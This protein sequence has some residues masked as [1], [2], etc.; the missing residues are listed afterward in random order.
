MAEDEQCQACQRCM[1]SLYIETY[2]GRRL[3]YQCVRAWKRLDGIARELYDRE[4]A[5]EEFLDPRPSWF[6][7]RLAKLEKT[8][9]D[10]LD[11][12]VSGERKY[13]KH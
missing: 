1:L 9:V 3:C 8:M 12:D 2:R 11:L 13:I 4:A 7:G 5:W 6:K 10:E